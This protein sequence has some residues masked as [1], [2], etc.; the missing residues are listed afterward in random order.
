[1]STSDASLKVEITIKTYPKA[2]KDY[3]KVDM[4]KTIKIVKIWNVKYTKIDPYFTSLK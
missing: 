4:N 1:M 3:L 2:I